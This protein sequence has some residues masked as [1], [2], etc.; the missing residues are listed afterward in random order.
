MVRSE[1]DLP[2]FRVTLW[3][4]AALSTSVSQDTSLVN[5]RGSTLR[6][7]VVDGRTPGD[8]APLVLGCDL[9]IHAAQIVR[10]SL[11]GQGAIEEAL[12]QAN[13]Y[14]NAEQDPDRT[15]FPEAT[16]V[17]ADID[18]EKVSVVQAGDCDAWT[19][20]TAG[21]GRLFP[22]GAMTGEAAERDR[23]WYREHA[24]LDI[25][26]LLRLERARDYVNDE[27]AWRTAAVGRFA[28]P[29][30]ARVDLREW[31]VLLLTTDGARLTPERIASLE[32]W[33][34]GLR[35]WEVASLHERGVLARKPHD[36]VTVLRIER[37]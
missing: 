24:G 2:G 19:L 23:Q 21:W 30:L 15:A 20:E 33:L 14:L 9:G 12:A 3:E 18:A 31:E 36:D 13:A 10:H 34:D 17:V 5:P 22:E 26:D 35:A 16:C 27:S 4:V 6:V 8:E 11:Y 25:N 1:I 32:D 29:K 28:A 37:T 7:G